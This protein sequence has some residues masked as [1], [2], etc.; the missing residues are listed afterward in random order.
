MNMLEIWALS[1]KLTNFFLTMLI[2]Q[3][4]PTI[5]SGA[6]WIPWTNKMCRLQT[7]YYIHNML[8]YFNIQF[9]LYN[10]VIELM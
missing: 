1:R 4:I 8:L 7:K 3:F 9:N 2:F 5:I 6:D 10:G